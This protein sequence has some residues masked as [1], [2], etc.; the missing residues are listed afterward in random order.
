MKIYINNVVELLSLIVA[1]SNYSCLRKSPLRGF[2]PF[3]TFIFFGELFENY[4]KNILYES[5][6]GINYLIGVVESFFYGYVF[7]L[8]SNL[9]GL[10]IA[11]IF[12]IFFSICGYCTTYFLDS[13]NPIFFMINLIIS[14]FFLTA[15]ALISLY[16][17]FIEDDNI[18][19]IDPTELRV[20]VPNGAISC[21]VYVQ[22]ST[23]IST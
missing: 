7:Y 3:L 16:I 8:L 12:F 4:Q 18:I 14:G 23:E 13:K 2:I 11:I 1:I 20:N 17:K 9:K 15:I 22:T 10:K 21:N 5:T 19:L 6:L